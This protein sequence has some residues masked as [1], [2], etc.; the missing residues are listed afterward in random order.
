MTQNVP[1]PPLAISHNRQVSTLR[2]R[3]SDFHLKH[4]P[5]DAC[6]PKLAAELEDPVSGRVMRVSTTALGMQLY[7]GNFIE[8]VRGKDGA[9]YRK[10]AGLCLE[11]QVLRGL[12]STRLIPL[13]A[14]G[15][16]HQ[17]CRHITFP[18]FRYQAIIEAGILEDFCSSSIHF[19]PHL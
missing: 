5:A 13:C 15:T 12:S 19:N 17:C 2:C 8:N 7:T 10:H 9:V 11:T 1:T 6:R 14:P 16:M 18:A 4:M 3:A